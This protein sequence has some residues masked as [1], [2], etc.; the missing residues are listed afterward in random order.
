MSNSATFKSH[1]E[2]VVKEGKRLSG[3]VLRTFRTRERICMLTLWKSFILPK[4][5]FSC[6]LWNPHQISEIEDLDGL[7]R[8]FTSKIYG[9]EEKSYWQ[10]LTELNL[11]S[12]QRRRERYCIFY[13]WKILEGLVPNEIGLTLS[14]IKS[15]GRS[16]YIEG[17]KTNCA[18]LK[19]IRGNSF[20]RTGP[21]MFNCLPAYIKNI[22]SCPFE[23]F[24]KEVDKFLVKIEDTPPTNSYCSTWPHYNRLE[25]LVPMYLKQHGGSRGISCI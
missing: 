3:W 6:Q 21:K 9:M 20:G 14:Q 16:C 2:N 12:L 11:Y 13:I 24:K 8:S 25:N 5:E 17:P 18:S 4:L 10:R 19:T 22:S 23:K 15:R 1:I 7:Q